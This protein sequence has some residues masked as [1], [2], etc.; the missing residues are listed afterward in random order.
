[1]TNASAVPTTPRTT[2]RG[3]RAEV[4]VWPGV[5]AMPTGSV[6]SPATVT[7]DPRRLHRG[8]L[9]V[10]ALD[11]E[12]R[13]PVEERRADHRQRAEELLERVRRTRRRRPAPRPPG[14]AACPTPWRR[15]IDSLGRMNGASSAMNS[16]AGEI[17]T[18]VSPLGTTCSP[19]VI[20]RNGARHGGQRQD[21]RPLRPL[22]HVAQRRARQA[23]RA[24][25]DEQHDRR[26]QA[27][28]RRRSSRP[29][30][31]RART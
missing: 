27:A 8:Q 13:E 30:S 22:A 4:G 20:S 7:R 29:R 25:D 17:S 11:D 28:E 23:A 6:M 26:E 5:V 9:A 31:R 19:K 14:R 10:A 2:Q 3:D 1:M 24:Q 21:Q 18:A 16:E 12:A 15:S